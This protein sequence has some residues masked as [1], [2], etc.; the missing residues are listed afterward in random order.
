MLKEEFRSHASYSGQERFLTFPVFVFLIATVV[1]LTLE[2]TMETV[3][4]TQMMEFS[5]LSAFIYGLSVGTFGLMGRQYLERR[6]GRSNYLV[7]MPYILPMSFKTTFLGIYLRDAIF[8]LILMLVPATCGLLVAA[9][10]MG[11]SYL[12][13][14][15]FFGAILLT[16]MVG[17]S[18]SFL[19]SVMYIRD[20]RAFGGFTA[21]VAALFVLHGAF[22]LVPLEAVL[23]PLGMQM[24]VRPFAVDGAEALL[25]AAVSVAEVAAMTGLAYAMVEVRISITSQSY[26]DVLPRYHEKMGWLKGLTR[27]LFAKEF[28]DLK[29]SGT[30]AKMSFSFVLPLL[31]L[32][33]TTWFVNY[34]LAIPVGFNTVFYASMVGFVGVMMYSWLNNIDLAEYYSLIPVT[35]PQ[36]IKVRV[37]VFLVLTL[38][39][40]ASFVVGISFLNDELGYLWLALL[41][42]FVTSLYMVLVLAYLTGLRTNTFLFDTSVLAKFSVMSFLPDVC[43]VI[44]SFTLKTEWAFA[45]LGLALVLSSMFATSMILFRGIES[46]WGRSSFTE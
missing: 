7:A 39:I 14:G 21:A 45:L 24:N 28:V 30:V 12:S 17:L 46:K 25:F 44:L 40:S 22:G 20:K 31:F 43:L 41:V 35:V 1:A 18:M 10:I 32:S 13:I 8:Y 2:K 4:L 6:Y 3:S 19:A 23:P 9:P 11:Y 42:M 26:P 27:T 38:G 37:A 16:F 34:G 15:L 36:L 29:R 33:F 5:H